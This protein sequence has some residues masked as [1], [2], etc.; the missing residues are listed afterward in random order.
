MKHFVVRKTGN[1]Y[2][3]EKYSFDGIPEMI[4]H[5]LSKGE[6]ISNKDSDTILRNPIGRQS[7]ELLHED[8]EALKKLGEGAYGMFAMFLHIFLM[9]TC[10]RRSPYG[11]TST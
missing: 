4:T 7:W 8:I 3:I 2:S 5:H 6:S 9:K 1:K 10:F 11:K